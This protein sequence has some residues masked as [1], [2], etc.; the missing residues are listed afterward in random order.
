M[1]LNQN[2]SL[3]QPAV[4]EENSLAAAMRRGQKKISDT[5]SKGDPTQPL[6]SQA[7]RYYLNQLQQAN[8]QF[9]ATA[10][11]ESR[12]ALTEALSKAEQLYKDQ[13]SKN[14]WLELAQILGRA[15]TQYAAAQAG[16]SHS[17]R[18]G[19]NNAGLDMG[20]AVDYNARTDRAARDYGQSMKNILDI[21]DVQQRE[22]SN[23]EK[24]GKESYERAKEAPEK[25]LAAALREEEISRQEIGDQLRFNRG[26]RA[27]KDTED[28]ALRA[29][30]LKDL[31]QQDKSLSEKIKARQTLSNLL[32]QE[33]DLSSKSAN[34]LQEKYGAVAAAGDVDLAALQ[35]E[36]ANAKKPMTIMGINTPF[37]SED[38]KKQ[39]DL[40]NSKVDELHTLLDAVKARKAQI[41]NGGS[42]TAPPVATGE[43][44]TVPAKSPT[45]DSP[46][47]SK[48]RVKRKAD[49]QT[50]SILPADFD[51]TKYDR[52]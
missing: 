50:G 26:L 43:T 52:L 31:D 17:G 46:P 20:P 42:R 8:D 12:K 27:A 25:G 38:K 48:I 35:T 9:S 1:D 51:P 23:K 29:S 34:K 5:A 30:N 2:Q 39:S 13:A 49:G 37:N 45:P 18:Y 32:Q 24:A 40:L 6:H 3:G 14:E 36:M 21:N 7:A 28:R 44:S 22:Y 16:V 33:D 11:P 15:G 47:P 4:E 19:Q 41:L 10:P